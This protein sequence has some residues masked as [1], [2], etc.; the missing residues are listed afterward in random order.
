MPRK[1][2]NKT[3]S[4]KSVNCDFDFSSLLTYCNEEEK[5]I[6]MERLDSAPVSSCLLNKELYDSNDMEMSF[7]FLRR[8]GEDSLLYRFDKSEDQMGKTLEHFG[9]CFYILDP[10]SARIS[11][12]LSSLL[13]KNFIS[14]DLCAAPGG[15]TIAL[16]LR[17]PDGL[18][19]ANDISFDRAVEID[20]NAQR[21]QKSNILTLSI[22]PMKLRI[23]D[24]FDLVIADVP[25]SGSGMIRK[26]RKM[27]ND[28]SME[29]VERLLPIQK[30]LLSKAYELCMANGI[31]A[32]STCSLSVEEDEDQVS[33]FLKSHPDC[34]L[35]D[36]DLQPG[37]VKG[38]DDIGYHMIP[39][40]YDGEGIYFALIR[41]GGNSSQNRH[42]MNKLKE[43]NSSGMKIYPYK[44]NFY[45]LPR[46]YEE[47]SNLP[48]IAPG[49]RRL[50]T[51]EHPK[52]EYDHAY[53][54]VKSEVPTYELTREQACGYVQGNELRVN[55]DCAEGLYVLT[56]QSMKLGFGKIVQGRI[57]NYLP[58]GL[59]GYLK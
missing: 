31:I 48:Y 4:S 23:P 12:Y 16:D 22:D 27:R 39:G 41:K 18:Y 26:E 50:D 49:I 15:K 6:F 10:S 14:I 37:M 20:K 2:K 47:L 52:C 56:Y 25:C 21:M 8:D 3:H 35:I 28:W 58:K 36:V 17:R 1:Q 51:S 32:Y 45:V 55:G 11:Y 40:I 43:E 46:M 34:S 19:L 30:D 53:S 7:P 44:N 42:L 54:K 57:K 38:R 33:L 29:K 59:R 13:D 9:G 5:K 24:Y